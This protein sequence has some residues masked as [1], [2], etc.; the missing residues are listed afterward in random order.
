[1]PSTITKAEQRYD[2]LLPKKR[3]VQSQ[4]AELMAAAK[5]WSALVW[6]EAEKLGPIT[7]SAEMLADGL[8]LAVHP[9]FICGVHRSGTTLVRNLLDCHPDLVVLPSEG[10]YF[11]NIEFKLL[12]L[13]EN[14]RLAYLGMEWLRRLANPINQPPYWLLG[15]STDESSPYVTFARYF[16]AWWGLLKEPEN[17]QWPHMAVV[18]AYASCTNN[19]KAK[20]WVDKTPVNER[21]I[22]RI[23]REMPNGK[24]IHV[25]RNPMDTLTSRKKMEPAI[26]IRHALRDMKLSFSFAAEYEND[27]RVMLLR[28]EELCNEPGAITRGLANFLSITYLP[29]L[30]QATVAGIPADANSSFELRGGSGQIV[31][32]ERHSSSGVLSIGEQ[33]LAA[34]YMGNLAGRFNYQ[35]AK[36]NALLKYYYML[37]YGLFLYLLIIYI[38]KM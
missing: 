26:T 3:L 7:L 5:E 4:P 24:I 21:F 9:V 15:R 30:Q 14:E 22:E 34:A 18:L 29:G 2:A 17:A 12:A 19:I 37:K 32:G 38:N 36:S 28:Y 6:D 35:M 11:T 8:N 13:P 1:M 23:W 25:L 10:T 31:K 33:Q 20:Y 27:T 16:M